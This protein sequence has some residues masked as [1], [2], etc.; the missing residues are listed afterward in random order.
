VIAGVVS[1]WTP[2]CGSAP[3]PAEGLGRWN[4]DPWQLAAL[5]GLA[6]GW[7]LAVGR[8]EPERR[9]WFAGGFALLLILFVSPFCAMTSAL[10]SAR[11]AHHVLLTAVAAPLLVLALPSDRVR[12][13]GSIAWWT[14]VQ[15]LVFWVW[16]APAL[17]AAALSSDATYW[18]MQLTLLGS[19]MALWS[20]VRHASPPAAIAALLATMVQMGLLGALITFSATPLYVPHFATTLPWGFHPLEDQQLAGLIMWAPAAALYLAAAL[21]IAGRW[22]ALEDGAAA[23]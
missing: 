11:V 17:Y 5:A 10:F 6:T 20:A 21:F 15:A 18:L 8:S 16:H 2:Y 1:A 12:L 23:Q 7:Q 3:A 22:L 13:P 9:K 4:L 14:A 19:A